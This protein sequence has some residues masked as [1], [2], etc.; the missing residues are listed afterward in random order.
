MGDEGNWR[1][2]YSRQ[3][4]LGTIGEEGQ[5][6]LGEAKAVVVGAGGLGSN[7]V[8]LLVRMGFGSV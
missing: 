4:V 1:D 3:L 8:D 7:S 6:R 5:R 2:R